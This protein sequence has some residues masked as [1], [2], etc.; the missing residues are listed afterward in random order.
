MNRTIRAHIAHQKL[1]KI[2]DNFF[3]N[4]Q[5][6]CM[7][8]SISVEIF[9][10]DKLDKWFELQKIEC[11]ANW[12]VKLKSSIKVWSKIE[13]Q[14]RFFSFSSAQNGC[15]C[16]FYSL[17]CYFSSIYAN[18][19]FLRSN[20]IIH[21]LIKYSW[22]NSLNTHDE[23]SQHFFHFVLFFPHIGCNTRKH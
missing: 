3:A 8:N 11:Y 20:C 22:G 9:T 18:R 21:A 6:I 14:F 2:T 15:C 5:C 16:F 13:F 23:Y 7:E 19:S 12:S 10:C 4:R 17:C 1:K